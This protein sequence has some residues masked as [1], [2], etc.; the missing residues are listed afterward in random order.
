[1][2][3]T[4]VLIRFRRG[5]GQS[6]EIS[7][8]GAAT[9]QPMDV[10]GPTETRKLICPSTNRET[11][12]WPARPKQSSFTAPCRRYRRT[13]LLRKPRPRPYLTQASPRC[14]REPNQAV[15]AP[16]MQPGLGVS[17][18]FGSSPDQNVFRARFEKRKFP[19]PEI[20][21]AKFHSTMAPMTRTKGSGKNALPGDTSTLP[22]TTQGM[23]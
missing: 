12:R 9:W 23:D 1:M 5:V 17:V 7:K 21:F 14:K 18:C 3:L 15:L 8:Q 22:R 20:P 6:E 11:I 2:C 19:V 10:T 16:Y 13:R 4:P